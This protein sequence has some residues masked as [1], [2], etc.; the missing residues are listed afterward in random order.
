MDLNVKIQGKGYPILAL[1]GHPGSSESLSVFTHHLCQRFCTIAPDLRG[2]GDSRPTDA[3]QLAD[4]LTDLEVLLDKQGIE[5][6]ILLGWSLGGILALELVLRQPHRFDGLIL[7]ASAAAPRG[8]HPPTTKRDLAFTA[9]AGIVNY[10]YPGWQW[11][12]DTFGKKSLFRYLIS[13]QTPQAYH[14]LATSGVSAYLRTSKQA[15]QALN[16]ALR[17]GYNRLN[18][19][20]KITIP[21]LILAGED[22][23]H[24]TAQSSLKTAEALPNSH[25]HCYPNT[26][27]LFPWEIPQQVLKDID[28]WLNNYVL[29][30]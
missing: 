19:L 15:E 20:E 22:D 21:C 23:R 13:Q 25:Y 9:I 2:Y 24:I 30:S 5:R 27:H 3:F 28:S 1:H 6:C 12:I 26:A 29:L 7:V 8:N 11:N 10:F 17:S 4:H 14:Y 18:D 16:I